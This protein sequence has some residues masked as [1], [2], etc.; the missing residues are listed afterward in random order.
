LSNATVTP[1][2]SSPLYINSV[3][4]FEKPNLDKLEF[5]R[6]DG[7]FWTSKNTYILEL[8]EFA[9]IKKIIEHNI[10]I[11]TRNVLMCS[12]NI[13]FRIT[14]SWVNKHDVG[15]SVLKH[16]HNNSIFSGSLYLKTDDDSGDI[17]FHKSVNDYSLTPAALTLD[18]DGYNIYNSQ[19]WT[20]SPKVNDICLFPS[21]LE[22]SVNINKSNGQRQALAFNV[23]ISGKFGNLHKLEI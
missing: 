3:E 9:N 6:A 18:F 5:I 20:Y 7:I 11:Y 16:L 19:T 10:D 8:P 14:N 22:H 1:L 4:D 23:F 21:T 13:K 2:F 17:I 15:D 12:N